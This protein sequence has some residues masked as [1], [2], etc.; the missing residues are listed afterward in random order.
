VASSYTSERRAHLQGLA[1]VLPRHGLVSRMVGEEE[2][3]LWVWHPH[4]SR[5]TLVF[6]TPSERGWLFLWAPG[7]TGGADDLDRTAR[8]LRETLGSA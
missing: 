3:L 8:A 5:Q 4:T 1:E 2:P 6:A 7:G